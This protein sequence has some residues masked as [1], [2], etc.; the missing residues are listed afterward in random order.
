MR[1]LGRVAVLRDKLIVV[2]FAD[3]Q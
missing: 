2:A 3:S 1:F